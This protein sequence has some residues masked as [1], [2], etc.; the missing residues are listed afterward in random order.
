MNNF[1]QSHIKAL[2]RVLSLPQ[3]RCFITLIITGIIIASI[4]FIEDAEAKATLILEGITDSDITQAVEHQI[5]ID[6]SVDGHLIDVTTVDGIVTLSGSVDNILAKNQAL[7]IA[8]ALRGVRSVINRIQV[9]PIVRSDNEILRDVKA[10]LTNNY[11]T[12]N[13]DITAEVKNSIVTLTGRVG[14]W[15]AKELVKKVVSGVK[16]IIGIENKITIDYD[17]HRLDSEIEAEIKQRFTFDPFLNHD[18]IEIAVSNGSVTLQ[19][20]VNSSATKSRAYN[21]SWVLGVTSVDISK[22]E[23]IPKANSAFL[24]ESALLVRTDDTIK[25]SLEDA[26]RYDPRTAPFDVVLDVYKGTVTLVGTVGSLQAKRAA[27]QDAKNTT[28]VRRVK[29]HLKVRLDNPP[30]DSVILKKVLNGLN[31]DPI[32]DRYDIT[33]KVKNRKV[34]LSGTVD[35]YYEWERADLIAAEIFGVLDVINDLKVNRNWT[36]KADEHIKE[37]IQNELLWSIYVDGDDISVS[38]VNGI[39]TLDGIIEDRQELEAAIKNAFEGGA[40]GV[41]C[42]LKDNQGNTYYGEYYDPNV[43]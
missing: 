1:T 19:G 25:K 4:G 24:K 36:K 6:E 12:S 8:E 2:F 5:V 7:R 9:M 37:D 3:P 16:G 10:A 33:V 43:L 20:Q 42:H 11:V 26:L 32:V 38:V 15:D 39:V 21:R 40:Q 17:A 14:S 28:G 30:E 23:V 34:Y 18:L 41:R 29:N 13:Y 31:R 27:E 22:L 35:T